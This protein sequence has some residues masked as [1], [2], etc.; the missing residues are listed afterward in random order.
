MNLN[1]LYLAKVIKTK[2]KTYLY[3]ALNNYIIDLPKHIFCNNIIDDKYYY[4]L[5]KAKN[6]RDFTHPVEFRIKYPYTN[7]ELFNL[8]KKNI[9]SVTL[10]LTEQCNFRCKYCAYMSKYL[11]MPFN[12]DEMSESVLI[13]AV[14]TLL[15]SD[16][17]WKVPPSISFYGGEPLLK[18]DLIKSCIKYC[19]NKFVYK[20]NFYITTNGLL[21]DN[22]NIIDFLIEN[23]FY[24]TISL[25]GPQSIHDKYRLQI[26]G[27]PSFEKVF[28]NI[29]KLYK[30]N[31]AFFKEHVQFN[32]VVTP[33]TG[34]AEQFEFLENLCQLGTTLIDCTLT[35]YFSKLI[36]KERTTPKKETI[37]AKKSFL[38]EKS[39]LKNMQ[40]YHTLLNNSVFQQDILPGGFCI[41]G[42]RKNFVTTDGKIIVCEKVNENET[43]Y[44]IGNIFGGFDFNKIEN[45][46]NKAVEKTQRCKNCWAAKFCAICF[47]DIFSLTDEFC[48]KSR[49]IVEKDLIYYLENI[50]NNKKLINYLEN[51]SIG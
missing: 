27:H 9:P 5:I 25:D 1:E 32:A 40:K 41:P 16:Y 14:D 11:K 47:K 28:K 34:T 4:Q 15:N 12:L 38:V 45:L 51:L 36:E 44:Q 13:K 26:N 49:N 48:E 43:S 31:P 22:E 39:T 8:I 21:L 20:P 30:I 24:L 17:M 42:T 3:D 46:I 29:V 10:A 35:N 2:D 33:T 50:K 6:L 7:L 18:F 19:E 37:E 23:N